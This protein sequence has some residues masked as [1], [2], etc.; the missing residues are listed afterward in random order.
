MLE[1]DAEMGQKQALNEPIITQQ[2][3]LLKRA[4]STSIPTRVQL[5][6]NTSISAVLSFTP[7]LPIRDQLGRNI[8]EIELFDEG[9]VL[10]DR[11]RLHKAVGG[12]VSSG[13]PFELDAV[14]LDLLSELMTIDI[15]VLKL[16]NEL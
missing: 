4:K 10:L 7:W 1:I 2:K 14:S 11:K 8:N 3:E 6:A 5:H 13:Y 16:G 15:D 12:H 9:G